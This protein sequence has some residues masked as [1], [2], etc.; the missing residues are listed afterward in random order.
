VRVLDDDAERTKSVVLPE[1]GSP[2]RVLV[3]WEGFARTFELPAGSAT[4]GRGPDCRV[5]IEHPSVSRQHAVLHIGSSVAIE[6]LG[7][8]NGTRVGGRRLPRASIETLAPG[9]LVEVGLATLVVHGGAR[10]EGDDNAL[11]PLASDSQEPTLA[12]L[13]R[14]VKMVASSRISVILHGETGVGKEVC[15]GMLHRQSPRANGPFIKI[16]CA[17]LPDALLEGELFGHE[18]GAFTGATQQ[19]QGLV[20]A[21][22]GGTILLDE[23]A[24][25]PLVT[26]AKLLRVLESREVMR[27]GAVTPRP[28]DVR[29]VCATHADLEAR[30]RAGTFRSDLFFRLNGITITIPPLRD[31]R[32]QIA[33][34]ARDFVAAACRD[35]GHPVVSVSPEAMRRLERHDWP[36]NV[37]ELKNVCERAVLLAGGGTITP[38]HLAGI[39]GDTEPAGRAALLPVAADASGALKTELSTIEHRRILEALQKSGGNQSKAA[40]LL[41]MSR[42]TLLHRLDEYGVPRPRKGP[43]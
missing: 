31:R 13:E 11:V 28:I 7:S 5:R 41:G 33:S 42:R 17:A 14:L 38:E 20:E 16:N 9:T 39:D 3:F 10:L 18:R 43:R 27:I 2:R 12:R 19:K 30:S 23:V 6:D 15:A 40:A 35:N 32:T 26:Q 36:G 34:L 1:G 25:L 8:S 29:F 22:H 21:A 37:R 4:I 24:E